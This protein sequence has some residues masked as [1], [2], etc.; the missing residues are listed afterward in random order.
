MF[1]QY[2]FLREGGLRCCATLRA[3]SFVLYLLY[4]T[5]HF[6]SESWFNFIVVENY[7]Y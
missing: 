3:T 2:V 6:S 1:K 4:R 5:Q 7:Y